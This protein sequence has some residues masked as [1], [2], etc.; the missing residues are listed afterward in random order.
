MEL[1]EKKENSIKIQEDIE[2][3]MIN[4][5]RRYVNHIPIIAIDEI[6]I[7]KNDSPLYDETIAHRIGLIPL[8]YKKIDSKNPP[9]L[10]LS[11][12][13][14]GYVYSEELK[15]DI[16]PT[17]NKIPITSLNK[18]KELELSAK[19]K[20]GTGIEHSKFAPGIIFYREI[21]DIKL[22]NNASLELI[23]ICPK[24]VFEEKNGK[25]SVKDN[26]K[27]DF[28][29]ECLDWNSK[30]GKD[31]IKISPTNKILITI[32]SFG[33]LKPEEIFKKSLEQLKKDLEIVAKTI[34]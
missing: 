11:S 8:K 15:G 13:K 31:S 18:N 10:K 34:K 27:C 9:E 19:I 33:Q 30:N 32:E 21:F 7:S 17:Y 14:E 1:I 23:N 29:E 25:L 24:K 5:I 26:T 28:C 4:A 12:K 20:T 2:D 22:E 16:E 3:S 6:E